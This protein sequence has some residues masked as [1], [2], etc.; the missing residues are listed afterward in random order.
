VVEKEK[1]LGR[2][3]AAKYLGLS[4]RALDGLQLPKIRPVAG[5]VL[6]DK[7]DLDKFMSEKKTA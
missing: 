6:F 2:Q 1:Y 4:Q 5:R 3:E 7:A